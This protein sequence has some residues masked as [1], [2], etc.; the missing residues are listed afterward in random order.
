MAWK[1]VQTYPFCKKLSWTL[2]L[3][4]QGSPWWGCGDRFLRQGSGKNEILGCLLAFTWQHLM[5]G[6][7]CRDMMDTTWHGTALHDTAQQTRHSKTD[8][9]WPTRQIQ[10]MMDMTDMTWRTTRGCPNQNYLLVLAS[11]TTTGTG[12]PVLDQF[13]LKNAETWTH[14]GFSWKRL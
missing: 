11:T 8:M 6:S 14:L 12:I 3:F 13:V 4:M 7:P 2:G 10:H 9:A 5:E 1:V